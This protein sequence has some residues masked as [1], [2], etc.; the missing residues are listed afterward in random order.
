MFYSNAGFVC[1]F[2]ERLRG[3]FN[4]QNI[5]NKAIKLLPTATYIHKELLLQYLVTIISL[6]ISPSYLSIPTKC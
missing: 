4:L 2:G 6:I 5:I 1:L 3:H